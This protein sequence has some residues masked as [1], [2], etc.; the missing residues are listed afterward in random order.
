MTIFCENNFVG[1]CSSGGRKMFSTHYFSSHLKI[2][3]L[4]HLEMLVQRF[5]K[6]VT[7][8]FLS[9]LSW[10]PDT[11]LVLLTTVLSS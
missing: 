6:K 2:T 1:L 5:F 10:S 11:S 9:S 3:N 4:T 8:F 7:F